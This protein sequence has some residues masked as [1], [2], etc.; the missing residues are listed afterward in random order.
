MVDLPAPLGPVRNAN[1]PLATVNEAL[2]RATP[3]RGYSLVTCEKRIT[4]WLLEAGTG[5]A[6]GRR[7]T[8]ATVVEVARLAGGAAFQSNDYRPSSSVTSSFQRLGGVGDEVVGVLDAHADADEAIRDTDRGSLGGRHRG[9]RRES[10]LRD[11]RVDASQTRCVRH[12]PQTADEALGR[13]AA[14]RELDG[15]HTAESVQGCTRDFVIRMRRQARVVH[16]G[17]LG[18]LGAP[19]GETHRVLV[20]PVE[21][22]V[23]GLE[24]TLEEP[25]R[26]R[27][28]RLS[29]DHH[30]L[31]HFLD[32]RGRA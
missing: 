5:V 4:G 6:A 20:V 12:D 14:T 16:A 27:I 1:S 17:E 32:V 23:D 3:L 19:L 18:P 10:R 8:R 9:V 25:C 26:E 28:R 2:L 15:H 21:S 31:P 11:E 22:D 24:A 13:I 7:W 29:P 30:L